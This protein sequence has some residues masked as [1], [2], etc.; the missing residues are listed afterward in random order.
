MKTLTISVLA[1]SFWVSATKAQSVPAKVTT[2]LNQ[3]YAGWKPLPGTCDNREWFRTGDFNGDGL[4]DYLVRIKTGNSAKS[5]RVKLIA[6]FKSSDDK[7][8]PSEIL[9]DSYRGDLV[10]SSFA[11]IKKGGQ[12]QLGEG[13]G[14]II[15]IEN[16]A[17][18]QY[19]CETDAIKT[20][21]FKDLKWKNIY[22]Q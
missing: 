5:F 10:R 13:D 18:S 12:I 14:P 7:Y 3:H 21:I 15:T 17:A 20:F 16:D 19:I 1:L 11:V 2:L 9:S 6:F 4:T 8:S 22:D